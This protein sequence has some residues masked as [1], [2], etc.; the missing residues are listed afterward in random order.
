MM[1]NEAQIPSTHLQLR[2]SMGSSSRL[3][4]VGAEPHVIR[5]IKSEPA[6]FLI[7]GLYNI[8]KFKGSKCYF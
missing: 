3:L 5:I 1:S 2:T 4:R 6:S 7:N 8:L